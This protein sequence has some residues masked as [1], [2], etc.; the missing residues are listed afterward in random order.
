M[1]I[2]RDTL[3][4]LPTDITDE[5]A[6]RQVLTR[7]VEQLDLIIGLRDTQKVGTYSQVVPSL[8]YSQAEAAQ[9]A[10]DLKLLF[11]RVEVLEARLTP[12]SG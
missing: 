6:L 4:S 11:D 7:L 5:I 2:E 1:S 8:V 9:M 12:V 10:L 3:L